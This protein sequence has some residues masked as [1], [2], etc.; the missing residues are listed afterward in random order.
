MN[1]KQL[2]KRLKNEDDIDQVKMYK[3]R[4]H[5]LDEDEC[6]DVEELDEEVYDFVKRHL[7]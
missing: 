4:K 1:N 2:N 3:Q 5:Q 6:I 7:K